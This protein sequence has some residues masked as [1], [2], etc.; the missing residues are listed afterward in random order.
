MKT[1]ARIDTMALVLEE[2]LSDPLW[3]I[4]VEILLKLR[5]LASL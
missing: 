3:Y 2:Y 1:K 4:P 5:I